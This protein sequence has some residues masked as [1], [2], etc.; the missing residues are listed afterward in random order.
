MST[1]PATRAMSSSFTEEELFALERKSIAGEGAA[2]L[3]HEVNNVLTPLMTFADF[4]MQTGQEKDLVRALELALKQGQRAVDLVR[5]FADFADQKPDGAEAVAVQSAWDDAIAIFARPLEKDRIQS[6]VNIAAD[7]IVR[8]EPTLFSQLLLI[9]IRDTRA[10]QLET[11]GSFSLTAARDG[12][13]VVMQFADQRPANTDAIAARRAFLA[14]KGE[15]DSRGVDFDF[16]ICR[17]I[18][19]RFGAAIELAPAESEKYQLTLRWPA[20][21]AATTA[22]S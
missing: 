11:G 10:A 20:A 16:R 13:Q 3:A 2:L 6:S 12:D 1:N 8:A 4:A 7:A 15:S 5:R 19:D 17:L 22:A 18:A 21:D 9:L 14:N